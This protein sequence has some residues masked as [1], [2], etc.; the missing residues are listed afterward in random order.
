MHGASFDKLYAMA[1][2]ALYKSKLDSSMV[3][4]CK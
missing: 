4:F 3:V 1:D 2:R